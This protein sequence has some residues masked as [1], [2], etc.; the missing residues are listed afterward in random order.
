MNQL[1]KTSEVETHPLTNWKNAPTLQN[2]KQDLLDAKNVH[3]AQQTKIAEWLDNLNVTGKAKVQTPKGNSAIVPKL[4]RKQAE[5]RYASLSEP[6]LS[7]DDIFNVKPV[8]WEDRNA[9]H[10]N[11]LVL[12]HQFN[13]ALD[14]THFV[15]E[16]VRAA[17]DEGT[18]IVRVGWEFIEEEYTGTFP[19]IEFRVNPELGPLH[20]HLNQLMEESPSEYETDVPEE[21]KQAHELTMEQGQPI[22]A[23][24]IGQKEE[25]RT[26]TVSNRPTLEVCDYRNVIIDPTCMGD[27]DKAGF[28][29]YSFES[30][31]SQLEKEGKKYKNLDQINISNNSI[32]GTPDHHSS[33]G[34]KSFNFSDE[35]R[36]KFVVY[37]YWG[38]WD[39]DGSG[40]VQPF[41]ASWVGNTMIR[42]EE[43]PFPDKKIPFVIEQ[44]LPVRKSSYGEPDGALLEDNQKIIGAVTR[45]MIDIMGKSANGQTGLRKD[46]LDTTNKRK[47]DKG[48]DYEFNSNV[49]PHQGVYMHTYPEIPASA[50]FMLGLQNQEAES[51]T[52]VK[53]YSQ[54]VSG[55]SLGDVAAG[56]RGA[57]DA[58]SKRELGILRRLSNGLVK[59]GR[60]MISMNAEFLSDTEVI[61]ITNDEFAVV[62]KDDL[63]GNFDLRLSISTAEEDNNK[64]EQLAFLF[65]TVGP[66]ADPDLTKMILADIAKLR[67]MPDLA[68]RIEAY[69][70]QPDP[71]VQQ[72]AQLEIEL[73]KAQLATEQAKAAS[74]QSQAQL[75]LAKAGTEGVKQ[76]NLQS[77]TDLKNL[78][79]V[80]QESGVKQERAK[81]L[82][83]EQARSQVQL[84]LLDREFTKEDQKTDLLKEYLK[85]KGQ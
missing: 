46:M 35:P 15:D 24:I 58:A 25:K 53:S 55:A 51:M 44:Y 26:R 73:L 28:V 54:G 71:L 4:I 81:E 79:F 72:K 56:V 29:I 82:H 68:K 39:I 45:G 80:E 31:L 78:D 34:T 74:Y 77:D 65:Q 85:N 11:Q 50:Q 16:Y 8:T 70:P 47:F 83:G 1:N 38:Y 61:R 66:N 42:M 5:W 62:K 63:P 6:F 14:K 64:A 7:T 2:L 3:D 20:E 69:Q 30:S 33:D 27:I 57:L 13:V 40:V 75:D 23:V 22:E 9:A 49:D 18:V 32:L 37:E 21:L 84:K 52:G 60:K 12:N 59:I 17:V 10:Q 41:V 76:G 43:N 67:K 36:K 19:V 48:Q